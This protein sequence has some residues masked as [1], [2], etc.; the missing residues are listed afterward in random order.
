MARKAEK[1]LEQIV[2]EVGRYPIDAYVFVQECISLATDRVHGAMAPTLHTVATWMAQEGLTPE[3]FRERW[4]IGELP[5]EIVE[6]V[7]QLGGPEKMNR[8]VTGQQLC[9]VIRDVAR[10]RWGLMARN[11]LARWGITRTEDLGE[12]VFALVNNGWLQ[13]QPTDTI[14][15]FNNVFSFAEAFDRTYR[16]LE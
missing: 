10:E 12:I 8:H 3:E 2:R 11:V 1:P 4:R 5:P 14:D 6:A 7:Q 9:E 15:D 16:M 13:K